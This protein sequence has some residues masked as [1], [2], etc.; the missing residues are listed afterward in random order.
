MNCLFCVSTFLKTH[1]DVILHH[2]FNIMTRLIEQSDLVIDMIIFFTLLNH[3]LTTIK[4][5]IFLGNWDIWMDN[6]KLNYFFFCYHSFTKIFNIL[7]IW[8]YGLESNIWWKEKIIIIFT[9]KKNYNDKKRYVYIRQ[10]IC[11]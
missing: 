6:Y 3:K 8:P 2:L 11:W 10:A 9:L 4:I 1:C 7:N 5:E